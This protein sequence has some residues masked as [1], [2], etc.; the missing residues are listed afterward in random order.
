M[1][2]NREN[3]EI[4]NS[5]DKNIK[6]L[7]E[8]FN[9]KGS[10]SENHPKTSHGIKRSVNHYSN[11]YNNM[12]NYKKTQSRYSK[13]LSANKYNKK[14]NVKKN[15]G[16]K[17]NAKITYDFC[18]KHPGFLYYK[19]I[20]SNQKNNKLNKKRTLTGKVINR[21]IKLD[22]VQKYYHTNNRIASNKMKKCEKFPKINY[23]CNKNVLNGK[24][25]YYNYNYNYN[26]IKDDKNNPYSIFW[27]NKILNHSDFRIEIKGN[28]YGVPKL[29][30]TT[31]NEDFLF[32]V[33]NK[34]KDNENTV[35]Y[36]TKTSHKSIN[37]NLINGNNKHYYNNFV[38]A[39]NQKKEKISKSIFDE[40]KNINNNEKCYKI[41][42]DITNNSNNK[43]ETKKISFTNDK[44]V[45]DN[46][47]N[48]NKEDKNN[49]E[50]NDD[51]FDNE[52]LDEEQQKQ[53]Y[54]NQKNFFKARKDIM[55]EPEYLEEDNDNEDLII[56]E[57]EKK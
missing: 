52:S 11:I 22:P 10:N 51:D 30:G 31:K 4:K 39:T 12:N 28:A 54:K 3:E 5:E 48:N 17:F 44:K 43:K 46:N 16:I 20:I 25:T 55:E 26:N 2:S 8:E 47:N 34:Q 49:K 19:E 6:I 21:K 36:S 15:N 56:G 50:N 41:K 9:N 13:A 18:K 45:E 57:G 14:I 40:N 27:A 29:V 33:F 24:Q 32:K 42:N 35:D 38:G 23:S 7:R 53:F 37:N 1:L